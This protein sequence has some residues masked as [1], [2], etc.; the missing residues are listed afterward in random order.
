MAV[1]DLFIQESLQDN[2]INSSENAVQTQKMVMTHPASCHSHLCWT[3]HGSDPMVKLLFCHPN[4][5]QYNTIVYLLCEEMQMHAWR[6]MCICVGQHVCV[7]TH[8]HYACKQAYMP[9]FT[10]TYLLWFYVQVHHKP[11]SYATFPHRELALSG[12]KALLHQPWH[13]LP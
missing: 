2:S 5:D 11:P 13:L 4:M 10:K 6:C 12:P 1:Y 8:V 3:H 7:C 9:M